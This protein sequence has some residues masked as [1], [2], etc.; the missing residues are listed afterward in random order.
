ML[1]TFFSTY[2]THSFHQFLRFARK[3]L[4]SL[5]EHFF[6]N[7]RNTKGTQTL[8]FF[9]NKH[10]TNETKQNSFTKCCF[11]LLMI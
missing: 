2:T 3:L 6:S 1:P 11:H 9:N 8:E 5:C 10:L 4:L 7:N